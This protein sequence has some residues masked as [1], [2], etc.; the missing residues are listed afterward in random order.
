MIV[1]KSI[2]LA[3]V[4]V[5]ATTFGASA[6]QVLMSGVLPQGDPSAAVDAEYG[7]VLRGAIVQALA[8]NTDAS[9]RQGRRLDNETLTRRVRDTFI[10]HGTMWN[11]FEGRV[12]DGPGFAKAFAQSAGGEGALNEWSRMLV[13]PVIRRL[14]AVQAPARDNYLT[15]IITEN[16]RRFALLRRAPQPIA[17]AFEQDKPNLKQILDRDNAAAVKAVDEFAQSN[18]DPSVERHLQF[19]DLQHSA[20]QEALKTDSLGK[21]GIFEIFPGIGDRFRSL[22][23]AISDQYP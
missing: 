17:V 5:A 3:V 23:I 8:A 4:A 13:Q 7:R 14:A 21:I 20:F 18:P 12:I 11:A 9:C 22:C 6:Q 19:S 1:S 15:Y 10:V 16:L 2:C